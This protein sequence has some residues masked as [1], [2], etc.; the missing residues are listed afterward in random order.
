MNRQEYHECRRQRWI[1]GQRAKFGN[2]ATADRPL[3]VQ[4]ELTIDHRAASRLVPRP[5]QRWSDTLY[6]E[7][8]SSRRLRVHELCWSRR[9]FPHARE[10]DTRKLRMALIR[11]HV[12]PVP[13]P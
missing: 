12:T 6:H 10:H 4:R 11:I 7:A 13:L 8:S 1:A 2:V 9:K 5:Q 3:W